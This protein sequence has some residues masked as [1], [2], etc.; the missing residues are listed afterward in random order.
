MLSD[1][2]Q[3]IGFAVINLEPDLVEFSRGRCIR[4]L[5]AKKMAR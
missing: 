3:S 5:P 1:S 4:L 2:F